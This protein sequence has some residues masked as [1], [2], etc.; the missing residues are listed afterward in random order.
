MSEPREW[1]GA[2]SERLRCCICGGDTRGADDYI[3]VELTAAPGQARQW[4]GAHAAHLN[5]VMAPGF[6][7]DIH[8]A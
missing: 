2:V 7:T 1:T 8:E 5:E 3:L 6:K 4:F